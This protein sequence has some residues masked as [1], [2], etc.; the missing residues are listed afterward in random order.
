MT[1]APSETPSLPGEQGAAGGG[2]NV[3]LG[4]NGA[5]DGAYIDTALPLTQYRMRIE[6]ADDIN[7]PDRA[8]YFYPQ[9]GC[10]RF[11]PP[12]T[13]GRNPNAPGPGT[14]PADHVNAEIFSNYL[15]WAPFKRFSAWIDVPYRWVDIFY[16]GTAHP[17]FFSGWSD[18]MFGF[19]GAIVYR[20]NTLVTFQWRTY[21]PTGDASRGLGRN[22]WN[23]EPGFLF[24]QRLSPRLFFEGQ[25]QDFIPVAAADDF[26][27]NVL[28]YGFS[29]NYLLYNRPNFRII[30]VYEMLGWNVLS[31]KELTPAGVQN[32]AGDTIFNA[33]FGVRLGFGQMILQNY[34]VN[35]ADIYLGY[36]RALTGDVWYKNMARA[37]FRIRF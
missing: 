33:K 28:N 17:E 16:T 8:D 12:G 4:Y 36:G 15:E 18:V 10:F 11:L 24:F 35:R 27:G 5:S 14:V 34:F 7:R 31:G 1:T 2:G 26:A 9:C 37:E 19:K 21:T 25:I 30:P 23:L 29:L 20:P 32:A 6:T 3:A 13:P 22:N